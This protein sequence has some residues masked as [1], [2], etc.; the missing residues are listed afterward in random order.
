M[1]RE[2]YNSHRFHRL[3][4]AT[5]QPQQSKSTAVDTSHTPDGTST[6]F[7]GCDESGSCWRQK[8]VQQAKKD[9]R[10]LQL[11]S[12]MDFC[13]L[14]HPEHAT[15]PPTYE[16]RT[17]LRVDDDTEDDTVSLMEVEHFL[18]SK[19]LNRYERDKI[20]WNR[21]CWGICEGLQNRRFQYFHH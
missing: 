2:A 9:R 15:Y 1:R 14:K 10:P 6:W 11:A 12:L 13:H 8:V 7:G 19:M 17:V 21:T 20:G 3:G 4:P 16:R 18:G 5:N